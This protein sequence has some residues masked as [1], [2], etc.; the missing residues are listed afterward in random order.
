MIKTL[1]TGL[2][3]LL[4]TSIYTYTVTDITGNSIAFTN[5]QDKKILIVNIASNSPRVNQIQQLEQLY[6]LY[7]DSLV[8]VAFPSNSFGNEPRT[9][10]GIDSFCH[11]NYNIHFLLTE[12]NPVTGANQQP[13]F[14]WL[15]SQ[16]LNGM[17]S[18]TIN[19]DFQKFLIDKNG[20]LIGLFGPTIEPISNLIQDAITDNN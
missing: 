9:N 13:I 10:A 11:T 15:A 7:S 14:Q 18:A 16:G 17:T 8:I 6:Q 20:S 2:A 5:F 1:I 19:N 4:T 3:V 12:K